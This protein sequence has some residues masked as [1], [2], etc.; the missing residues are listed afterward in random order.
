MAQRALVRFDALLNLAIA[1]TCP[2][3]AR[4]FVAREPSLASLAL[5]RQHDAN[6]LPVISLAM[7]VRDRRAKIF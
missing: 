1:P 2:K 7:M 3:K 5:L 4:R 6:N